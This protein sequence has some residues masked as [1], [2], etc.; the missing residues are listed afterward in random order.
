VEITKADYVKGGIG[1]VT[2][3]PLGA[4]LSP[5]VGRALVGRTWAWALIGVVAGPM[6]WVISTVPIALLTYQPERAS[7]PEAVEE[8]PAAAA[9]ESA[10][11]PDLVTSV[12]EQP[13]PVIERIPSE[14]AAIEEAALTA[15]TAPVPAPR[16]EPAPTPTPQPTAIVQAPSG[17]S[18]KSDCISKWGTDYRMIDYCVNKQTEALRSVQRI[19]SN[20]I[21]SQCQAKWGRDYRMI[22]YCY[23]KQVEAKQRL[24]I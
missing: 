6:S 14:R 4:V 3:G 22:D 16:Q 11:A 24:G 17:E 18:I 9:L 20:S 21:K 15:L 5:I 2:G 1:L 8:A 7:Q 10:A 23:R 13:A 19:P 12:P